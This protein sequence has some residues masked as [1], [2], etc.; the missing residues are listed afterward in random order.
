M[1]EELIEKT[2]HIEALEQL[3]EEQKIRKAR[4]NFIDFCNY[5]IKDEKSGN[6][7]EMAELQKSWVRHIAF[8]KKYNIHSMILAPMSCQLKGE[9]V[10]MYDGSTKA[11]E[12]IVIGDKLMGRNSTPRVVL[13]T[14]SGFAKYATI[15]THKGGIKYRVTMDHILTLVDTLHNNE[16]VDITVEAFLRLSKWRQVGMR[17]L[18]VGY[19]LPHRNVPLDPYVLGL[20]LGDGG[21][22]NSRFDLWVTDEEIQEYLEQWARNIPLYNLKSEVMTKE[23]G[24]KELLRYSVCGPDIRKVLE[25]LKLFRVSCENKFI[26]ELY[27]NN[28]EWVRRQILAGLIDTDGSRSTGGSID[29][30]NK[31]KQLATDVYE[32][33]RSLGLYASIS[34]CKKRATNSQNDEYGVYY[35]VYIGPDSG[36]IPVKVTRKIHNEVPSRDV[37]L[38]GFS[39]EP[40]EIEG[41]YFGFILDKDHRYLTEHGHLFHNSG[42]TQI[43]SVGIPLYYLGRDP[44]IRIKMV[45]LSDDA[46]KERLAS[47]KQYIETDADYK[48][49]FPHVKPGNG[50]WSS[51]KIFIDRGGPAKDASLTAKGVIASAIGGRCDLLLVDDIF[52]ENTA[53][54]QP[55]KREQIIKT[56]KSVWLSRIEPGCIAIVI[57]T[58]W[59]EADLAGIIMSDKTMMQ[60]Y[61]ILIQR[62][63]EDFSGIEMEAHIPDKLKDKYNKFCEGFTLADHS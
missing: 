28:S 48:K 16:L 58:R 32:I 23:E 54:A 59:H 11:V 61:G 40:H 45:C 27:K 6:P 53:V 56:Y 55:A 21:S 63:A 7:I 29:F 34:E 20:Y 33:A 22:M 31:S 5:V 42:K 36:V 35:R 25:D 13:E 1:T 2:E 57:M 39:V 8:C 50:E 60:R 15:T 51:H 47:V 24:N 44:K 46:A 9:R 62:V 3:I 10:R 49:V 17:L 18:Q 30:I 38:S 12:E 37:N 4:T 14:H 26:P 19:D 43:I 52:D 41:E